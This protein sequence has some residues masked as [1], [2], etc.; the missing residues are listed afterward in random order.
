MSLGRTRPENAHLPKR[1]R[2]VDTKVYFFECEA[3]VVGCQPEL[4]CRKGS[5]DAFETPRGQHPGGP[6]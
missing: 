6:L 4:P 2:D 3:H 5:I 1:T